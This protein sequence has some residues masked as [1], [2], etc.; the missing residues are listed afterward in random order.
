MSEQNRDRPA[1]NINVCGMEIQ[2]FRVG[3]T[4]LIGGDYIPPDVPIR[5]GNVHTHFTYEVFFVTDGSLRLV[6]ERGVT[7]YERK[8]VIIPPRIK[9][10]TRPSKKGSFCLLFSL[11]GSG[12][13]KLSEEFRDILSRNGGISV[14]DITDDIS[15]YIRKLAEK[16]DKGTDVSEKEAELLS[17]LLF[18]EMISLFMPELDEK[19]AKKSDSRH[20]SAIETYINANARGRIRLTDVAA[21]VFLSPRQVSRIIHKEYGCTLADLVLE[22]RLAN[23]EILLRSSDMKIGEI[24]QRTCIGSENYFYSVFKKKYGMSPL[25]FR[26]NCRNGQ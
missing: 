22:K 20:I 25:K 4:P 23:A 13:E 21:H 19:A 7:V 8:I 10:F 12:N 15:F 16:S 14:L 17:G 5:I 11:V 9:H 2:V 3:N 6:S 24:A 26:K 1:F 18:N